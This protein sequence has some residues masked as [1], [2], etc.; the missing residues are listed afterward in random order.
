M[1]TARQQP[2]LEQRVLEFIQ[3]HR[4]VPNQRKLLVA[5]SGGPDSVCLLHILIKLGD[6]LGVSLHLAHLNH[7]LRGAEAEADAD[8]VA[9]LARRLGIPAIIEQRDVAAYQARHHISLEEAAREV[10]YTFLAETAESIGAERVAV[11]HTIDDH[12]E[13]QPSPLGLNGWQ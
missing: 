12:I 9:D 5:V 3:E 8:Y 13:T 11:G 6:E 1:R 10:R 4:L 2:A 7:Q